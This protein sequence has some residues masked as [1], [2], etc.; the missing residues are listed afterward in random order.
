[1]QSHHICS[2]GNSMMLPPTFRTRSVV[3]VCVLLISLPLLFPYC[4]AIL[5]PVCMCVCNAF[6][7]F[8]VAYLGTMTD[9]VSDRCIKL[10]RY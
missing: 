1:M 7:F 9:T 5:P 2:P 8:Q 10:S 4:V 3:F 6:Y